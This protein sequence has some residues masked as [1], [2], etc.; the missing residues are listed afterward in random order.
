MFFALALIANDEDD[1]PA[2][3]PETFAPLTYQLN[4]TLQ[5]IHRVAMRRNATYAASRTV[6]KDDKVDTT[7]A[8]KTLNRASR[9]FSV[10]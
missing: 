7:T 9:R 1:N 10:R 8:W 3:S 4:D 2:T 5:Y 6:R